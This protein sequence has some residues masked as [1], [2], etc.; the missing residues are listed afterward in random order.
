LDKIQEY[1]RNWLKYINRMP[2]DGVPRITK[3]YRLKGGRKQR[4]PLKR[5]LDVG[6]RNGST[7]GPAPC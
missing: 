1:R 5:L 4:R 2:L 3:N 7:S 6:D